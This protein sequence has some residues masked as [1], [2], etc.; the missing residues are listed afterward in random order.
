MNTKNF[1]SG[2]ITL[3]ILFILSA[4]FT[5]AAFEDKFKGYAWSD[6]AGWISFNCSNTNTCE[7]V[8]YGVTADSSGNLSGFAWSDA[9][10]WLDFSYFSGGPNA[11]KINLSTGKLSGKAQF[12][13]ALA[14]NNDGWSGQFSLRGVSP[15]YGPILDWNTYKLDGYAWGDTVVG[16]TDFQTAYS[17][18]TYDPFYFLFTANKG[19]TPNNKVPYKGS[20]ILK[21]TTD[22]ANSCTATNGNSQWINSN[23]QTVGEPTQASQT[24]NN[25]TSDTLF[26]LSCTDSAGHT[27]VRDLNILVNPPAP[28]VVIG[29]D[30]TNIAYNTATNLNW[31][32]LHVSSC[33][34]SGD[35]SGSKP[36]GTNSQSTGNLTNSTNVFFLE[37]TSSYPSVYPN[38]VSDSIQIDVE[39]LVVDFYAEQNPVPY[40]DKIKLFWDLEFATDCTASG[41]VPGFSGPLANLNG[42][43]TFESVP[44][45]TEGVS[46]TA[47]I[48]CNGSNSQHEVKTLIIKVGKNPLYVEV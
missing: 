20:V 42:V 41:T 21:W 38:P 43:H 6:G 35:W 34:A 13:S 47:T 37:C 12:L 32:A 23:P 44:Q 48:T 3:F 9:L 16:W 29:A 25:L 45:T 24:I 39:R 10:G 2:I 40:N 8:D 1:L 5:S 36:V 27:I 30:D 11:A 26:S 4:Q 28:S 7:D 18:V 14:D 19:L 22:G 17:E 31:T 33:T 46:Y 15:N